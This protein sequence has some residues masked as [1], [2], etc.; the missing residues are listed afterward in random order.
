MAW[1]RVMARNPGG[2]ASRIKFRGRIRTISE[3]GLEFFE[4]DLDFED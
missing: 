3:G 1:G 4:L 2:R